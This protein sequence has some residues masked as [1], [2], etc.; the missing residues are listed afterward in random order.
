MIKPSLYYFWK[1]GIMV[2]VLLQKNIVSSTSIAA[3]VFPDSLLQVACE[4]KYL[5][6]T[7]RTSSLIQL[8]LRSQFYQP[9]NGGEH[10]IVQRFAKYIEFDKTDSTQNPFLKKK[11]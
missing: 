5:N 11:S 3:T 6:M 7:R 2:P 8:A 10:L 1:I 4:H 9:C